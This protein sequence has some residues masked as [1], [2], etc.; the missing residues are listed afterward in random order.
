M[1]SVSSARGT[2][3]DT[4]QGAQKAAHQAV[5]NRE[6]ESTPGQPFAKILPKILAVVLICSSGSSPLG[7]PP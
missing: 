7:L 5:Q 6:L 3:R 1:L 2:A 4:R